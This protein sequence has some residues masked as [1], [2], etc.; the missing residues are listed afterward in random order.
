MCTSF[1]RLIAVYVCLLFVVHCLSAFYGVVIDCESLTRLISADLGSMKEG[2]YRLTRAAFF[3]AR[4]VQVVAVAGILWS[5]W[6]ASSAAGYLGDFFRYL[7]FEPTQPAESMRPPC[8]LYLSTTVVQGGVQASVIELACMSLYCLSGVYITNCESYTGPIT[9]KPESIE[10]F[11]PE[12]THGTCFVERRREVI[13]VARLLWFWWYVL[14][15]ARFGWLIFCEELFTNAHG[16]QQ[17]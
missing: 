10:A 17:F 8:L 5:W 14:S 15:A 6:C 1:H 16:L 2:E 3:D 7:L 11:E 4:R 12:G 9:A 13:T